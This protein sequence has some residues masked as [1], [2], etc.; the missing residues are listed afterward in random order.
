MAGETRAAQAT[1]VSPQT[2]FWVLFATILASSMAF[3]DGSALNVAMP[4]LQADLKASGSELLWIVN[5]YTMLLAALLLVGGALGDQFGRKRIF[6][7]GIGLFA[8]ASLA[9]GLA[10]NPTIL[11]A[12]RA[13]QG[14]GGAL[15]I[16]GSLALISASFE[17]NQRGKA[18]GTWSSFSTITT[19]LG[20]VLGGVLADADLWRMV[21]F[22]NIPLALVALAVLAYKV[23]ESRAATTAQRL[24]YPGAL[25][26]TLGL[27][28][29][30]YGFT[31][32]PA[33]G[34]GD[35]L[36]LGALLGGGLAMLAFIAVELRSAWPM[37]PPVLFRSRTFNGTNAMTLFLYAA[38]YGLLFFFPLNLIQVQGYSETLAG[39][40]S[41]P[42]L[43][44]ITLLSPWAGSLID[45]YG[46]RL[47]LT[48]G[49]ALA[50]LGFLLFALPG[51]TSGPDAYWTSFFPATAMLG[52]GMAITV[53]PLST[54]VMTSVS[55]QRAG[56]ASGVNNAVSRVASVLAIAV[57]GAIALIAFR[58]NLTANIAELNLPTPARAALEA[59]AA[60]LGGAQV[61]STLDAPTAQAVAQAIDLAF[62]ATFRVLAAIA[63]GLAWLSAILAAVL[64]EPRLSVPADEP[65]AET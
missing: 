41:L 13:L 37:V 15:M 19:I 12:A 33:R 3:I 60:N 52:L 45:R 36:I 18:I 65:V 54:A 48:V 63:A 51:L 34:W 49:P 56:A 55:S 8:V 46:P 27:A 24:D 10:P 43:L 22:I 29:L 57:L 7:L 62:V 58:A 17:P 26:A 11:I 20:P 35:P 32:A 21:F 30:A 16:P 25:L 47:P 9:C 40:A 42:S 1:T 2:G 50:G 59:E 64:I 6:M 61:P 4:A 23:P 14:I 38:L 44:M 53:A 5:V 39:L 31:E 28:G